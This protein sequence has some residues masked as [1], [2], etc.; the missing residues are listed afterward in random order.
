[1]YSVDVYGKVIGQL[2]RY[3]V[4]VLADCLWMPSQ[5]ANLVRTIAQALGEGSDCC[6]IVVAGF[7]TG[8]GIVRDFFDVATSV[9]D[10]Q[11]VGGETETDRTTMVEAA[12][13]QRLPRL[14][15]EEIYEV[16]V[17]GQRRDWQKARPG[18]GKEE[19]KRWCVVAILVSL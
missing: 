1:M 15:I 7:H 5:H 2:G 17:D 19:A 4:I 13:G 6:A 10:G 18:E 12:G 3:D 16:D 9:G 8:R 14:K 11:G